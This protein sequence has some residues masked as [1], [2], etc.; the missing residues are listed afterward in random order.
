MRTE[1]DRKPGA[2]KSYSGAGIGVGIA[3]GVALGVAFDQLALGIA[4]G[5]AFGAAEA[6]EPLNQTITVTLALCRLSVP[7]AIGQEQ[8][9]LT[10]RC[11]TGSPP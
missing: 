9:F 10:Y 1:P 11:R 7:S 4:L 6:Q 3:A 5:T 8:S 2:R